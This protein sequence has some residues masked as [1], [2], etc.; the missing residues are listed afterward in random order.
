[1]ET[2]QLLEYIDIES[3]KELDLNPGIKRIDFGFIEGEFQQLRQHVADSHFTYDGKAS[4]HFEKQKFMKSDKFRIIT[5]GIII[6][7][8][9]I[10]LI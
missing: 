4:T 3:C 6:E 2:E 10:D 9:L 8:F 5:Q 1:M 7:I